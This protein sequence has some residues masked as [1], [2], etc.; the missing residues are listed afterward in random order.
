MEEITDES[1]SRTV[2]T[3][4]ALPNDRQTQSRVISRTPAQI[5]VNK[6]NANMAFVVTVVASDEDGNTAE[7]KYEHSIKGDIL[8]IV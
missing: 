3:K 4:L 8:L 6:E 7:C 5:T 1:E 2:D